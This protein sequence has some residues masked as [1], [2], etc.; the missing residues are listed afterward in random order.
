[1]CVSPF[2][3]SFYITRQLS[4]R[5]QEI[6]SATRAAISRVS[7]IILVLARHHVPLVDTI[8]TEAYDWVIEQGIS[9]A[10]ILSDEIGE[11][12][13]LSVTAEL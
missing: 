2:L 13:V 11:S 4:V 12:M 1:M 8:L 5:L 3:A 10:D 7:N 6:D 9:I